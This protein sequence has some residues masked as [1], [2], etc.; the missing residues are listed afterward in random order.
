MWGIKI[1]GK[2]D[3]FMAFDKSEH[4]RKKCEMLVEKGIVCKMVK[5]QVRE[6]TP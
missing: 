3:V 1:R 2:H 6:E 5:L 4:A